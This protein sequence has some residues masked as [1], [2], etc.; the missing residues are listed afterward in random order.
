[1]KTNDKSIIL[2]AIDLIKSTNSIQYALN[3]ANELIDN[4]WKDV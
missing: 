4:A 2:E 1:M 3:L